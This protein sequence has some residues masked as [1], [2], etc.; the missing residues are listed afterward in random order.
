[1]LNPMVQLELNGHKLRLI[2]SFTC[3]G[4]TTCLL[5]CNY[6][7]YKCRHQL[8]P[9]LQPQIHEHDQ[10]LV[11]CHPNQCKVGPTQAHSCMLE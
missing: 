10:H 7:H 2:C 9:T 4:T 11:R 6:C 5:C 3:E 8:L 1:M